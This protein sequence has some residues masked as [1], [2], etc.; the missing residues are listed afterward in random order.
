MMAVLFIYILVFIVL[1]RALDF[2]PALAPFQLGKVALGGALLYACA[3]ARAE[4]W[5]GLRQNP[6]TPCLAALVCFA[7][8]SVPFSVWRGGAFGNLLGY[9]KLLCAYVALCLLVRDAH[10]ATLRRAVTL[11]VGMLALLM[12]A[13]KGT[14]RMY[15]SSTY[16]PNDIALFFVTFLPLVAAEALTAQNRLMCAAY[17]GIA[18]AALVG[19]ALTQSRGG[20]VALAAVG[21]HF[22]LLVKRRRFSIIL[23][24]CLGAAVLAA[25]A[26][27]ALWARFRSLGDESDY[28]FEAKAGRLEIWKEGLIMFARRFLTGVGIG[29]FSAALGMIGSGLYVTAHNSYLQIAVEL[30]VG[31]IAVYLAMLW[32]VG[33]IARESPAASP[34]GG[35]ER[36]HGTALM[37]G[38]TGFAT[39]SFFLSQAYSPILYCL[40]AVASS[41][42]TARAGEAFAPG[43]PAPAP[44]GGAKPPLQGPSGALAPDLPAFKEPPAA[45]PAKGGKEGIAA[46]AK[47]VREARQAL[48]RK[49]HR[50]RGNEGGKP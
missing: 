11:T 9:L 29:Q 49:G 31:G 40:L 39:G 14:G 1:G 44:S 38:L 21:G 37:L 3:T 19:I 36:P 6:L 35:A 12:A 22:L 20:V 28:N 24:L 7:V 48:L 47:A 18:L 41:L 17:W 32:R 45:V 15:V 8:L 46:R 50:A 4:V 34:P 25:T 16:D 33:R 2:F 10:G 42:W 5:R 27:E 13:F 43:F 26:D 30:G 23:L